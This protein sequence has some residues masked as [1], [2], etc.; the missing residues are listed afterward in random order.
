MKVAFAA[1]SLSLVANI[2][3][4]DWTPNYRSGFYTGKAIYNGGSVTTKETMTSP[5]KTSGP[6][7][8]LA[9][10][11]YA[12]YDNVANNLNQSLAS[13]TA[14]YGGAYGA[15]FRGGS[16]TGSFNASLAGLAGERVGWNQMS[17]GGPTYIGYVQASG[18]V[19]GISYNCDI[20]VA[21]NNVALKITYNPSTGA[22]DPDTRYTYAQLNPV[23]N[24]HCTTI[25][26]WVPI[27][28]N[29]VNNYMNGK[30]SSMLTTAMNSLSTKILEAVIPYAPNYKGIYAAIPTGKYVVN[31]FDI[32]AYI[33]NNYSLLFTGRSMSFTLGA[34]TPAP[35]VYGNNDPEQLT[36]VNNVIDMDFSDGSTSL[37]FSVSDSR[38]YMFSWVCSLNDPNLKCPI[39]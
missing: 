29:M 14:T 6:M 16:L 33:K 4:A 34:F 8:D 9:A 11:V 19:Y 1:I 5:G 39:P 3:M 31:G 24:V 38:S 35:Q 15:V 10:S 21:A 2:A 32:G 22:V 27:L 18:S 26:D 20:S 30:I 37:R 17:L 12:S 28:G 25:F 36:Y 23:A 13:V 7:S